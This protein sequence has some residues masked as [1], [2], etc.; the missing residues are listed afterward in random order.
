MALFICIMEVNTTI[1]YHFKDLI[2]LQTL[3]LYRLNYSIP[4]NIL[5]QTL[6]SAFLFLNDSR[7]NI[8]DTE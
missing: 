6:N 7:Y 8:T 4:R 2:T 1:L 5:F 3:L